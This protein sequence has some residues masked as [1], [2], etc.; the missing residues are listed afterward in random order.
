MFQMW[1]QK[2]SLL[3]NADEGRGRAHDELR[4]LFQLRQA[5]EVLKYFSNFK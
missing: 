2:N 3:L 4:N 5:L 1:Q